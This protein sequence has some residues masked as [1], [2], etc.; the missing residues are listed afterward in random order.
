MLPDILDHLGPGALPIWMLMLK[1][2]FRRS[3]KLSTCGE[4][5]FLDEIC[6]DY[7]ILLLVVA[8]GSHYNLLVIFSFD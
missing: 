3:T 7:A 4:W 2:A 8:H 1:Y 5:G 6:I